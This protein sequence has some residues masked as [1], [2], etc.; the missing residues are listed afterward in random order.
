[1][2]S[3]RLQPYSTWVDCQWT[4]SW[5]SPHANTHWAT[6]LKLSNNFE[7]IIANKTNFFSVLLMCEIMIDKPPPAPY[8]TNPDPACLDTLTLRYDHTDQSFW[9]LHDDSATY[10]CCGGQRGDGQDAAG[11]GRIPGCQRR[12]WAWWKEQGAQGKAGALWCGEVLCWV[13][14]AAD[15]IIFARF[16]LQF[17]S[18]WTC[19]LLCASRPATKIHYNDLCVLLETMITCLTRM[20]GEIHVTAR[21][22]SS[23]Y[24]FDLAHLPT[25]S[26]DAIHIF[27]S[28]CMALI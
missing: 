28:T 3:D 17:T 21:A 10:R 9:Q 4:T 13:E 2:G 8:L 18:A 22:H 19:T 1:M 12:K 5:S 20:C 24:N 23:L 15:M 6:I 11:G 25:L 14:S 7:C 27:Y 16:L 26:K